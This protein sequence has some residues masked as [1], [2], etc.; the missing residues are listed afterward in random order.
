[1]GGNTVKHDSTNCGIEHWQQVQLSLSGGCR[2]DN[3]VE[4]DLEGDL[5]TFCVEG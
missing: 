3:D 1:M 5:S 4:E 2:D